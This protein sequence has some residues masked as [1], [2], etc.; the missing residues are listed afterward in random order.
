[1]S[2]RRTMTMGVYMAR[3]NKGWGNAQ[4]VLDDNGND[5]CK[6]LVLNIRSP[7]DL[8]YLR[9]QLNEIERDWKK[10]LADLAGGGGF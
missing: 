8:S 9:D 4:L 2:K 3:V 7:S 5:Q 1:M 6:R 10:S